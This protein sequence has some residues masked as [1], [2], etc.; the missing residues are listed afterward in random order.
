MPYDVR[1]EPFLKIHFEEHQRGKR[2]RWHIFYHRDRPG[3]PLLW[4]V[5][6]KPNPEVAAIEMLDGLRKIYPRIRFEIDFIKPAAQSL[7]VKAIFQP[8]MRR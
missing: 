4:A 8:G 1:P 5:S 6:W 3:S 2:A 7:P